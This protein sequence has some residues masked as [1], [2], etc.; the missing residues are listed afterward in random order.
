MDYAKMAL[1]KVEEL[2]NAV[3]IKKPERVKNA[4]FSS[5][6]HFPL[7]EGNDFI[8]GEITGS[9]A[10]SLMF[11][12]DADTVMPGRISVYVDSKRAGFCDLNAPGRFR[13]GIIATV[14]LFAPGRVMLKAEKGYRGTLEALSLVILG[15]KAGF[16][17]KK[18]DFAADS[19]GGTDAVIYSLN[20]RVICV[21]GYNSA[22]GFMSAETDLGSGF[23]ADICKG[24]EDS[25]YAVFS[26]SSDNLW[27][28]QLRDGAVLKQRRLGGG[29]QS[30]AIFY[31]EGSFIVAYVRN[32]KAYFLTVD[33]SLSYIS[34]EAL[35]AGGAKIDRVV[36]VKNAGPL[37]VLLTE[38]GG[39]IFI[40]RAQN[41]NFSTDI[42]KAA[43][44]AN[45]TERV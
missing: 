11:T 36:F 3:N 28:S 20:E 9:G 5:Y 24:P 12:A 35:I 22:A 18:A 42:F 19:L 25:F 7:R 17:R 6:P 14:Q 2:E 13:H 23:A 8:L 26:D 39:K 33:G 31:T 30:A 4:G 10:L 27:V 45:I 43:V 40:R 29:V 32:G 37:P 21:T 16:I 1:L 34:G 15:E 44:S 38:E 41:V